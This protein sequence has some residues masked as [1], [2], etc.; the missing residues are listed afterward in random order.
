MISPRLTAS[1]RFKQTGPGRSAD[2]QLS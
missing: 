1:N 2:R